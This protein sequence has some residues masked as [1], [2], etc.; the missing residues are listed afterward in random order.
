M[1][2]EVGFHDG[3]AFLDLGGLD[4]AGGEALLDGLN[5]AG[6]GFEAALGALGFDAAFGEVTALAGEL[7]FEG[8][9]LF[10]ELGLQLLL[11]G[12]GGGENWNSRVA[13]FRS[14]AVLAASRSRTL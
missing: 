2:L 3:Q 11:L 4:F 12:D 7:M 1:T 6:L 9:A 5:L 10:L 13:S 14:R 8:E